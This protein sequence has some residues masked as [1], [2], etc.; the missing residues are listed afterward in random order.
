M[1]QIF[2]TIA[3]AFMLSVAAAPSFSQTGKTPTYPPIDSD[4]LEQ[5][6]GPEG[7]RLW[8]ESLFHFIML[9]NRINKIFREFGNIE[10]QMYLNTQLLQLVLGGNDQE[11]QGASMAAAHSDLGITVTQFNAV[12]EAAYNACDRTNLTYEACNLM[13]AA[14]APFKHAIVTR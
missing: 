2:R 11:Y 3:I 10:R 14:L 4:A 7:V 12:V 8:V 5:F 9:D 6:G 13:I 1:K